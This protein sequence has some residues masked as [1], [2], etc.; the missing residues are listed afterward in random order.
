MDDYRSIRTS[1]LEA[2]IAWPASAATIVA[3]VVYETGARPDT[4]YNGLARLVRAGKLDRLA[5]GVYALPRAS[6]TLAPH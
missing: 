6:G 2:E 5:Y 3:Q 4:I 1:I